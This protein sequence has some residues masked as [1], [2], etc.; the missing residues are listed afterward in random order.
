MS[1]GAAQTPVL[2]RDTAWVA[3]ARDLRKPLASMEP[4]LRPGAFVYHHDH[5]LVPAE[6]AQEAVALL[7]ELSRAA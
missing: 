5:L 6:R 4:V 1:R 7:R 2:V 3:G